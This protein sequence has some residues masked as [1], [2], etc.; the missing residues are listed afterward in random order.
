MLDE[1]ILQD[2]E[3]TL[4][5]LLNISDMISKKLKIMFYELIFLYYIKIKSSVWIY[6][7]DKV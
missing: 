7:K 6:L 2:V 5:T 1:H 3:N 4:I